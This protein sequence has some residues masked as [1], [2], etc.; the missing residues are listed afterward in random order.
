MQRKSRILSD[1]DI[2]SIAQ[3]IL[4]GDS[5]ES[6]QDPSGV[7][8]LLDEPAPEQREAGLR[9]SKVFPTEH[10]LKQYLKEH[11]GADR[12]LHTVEESPHEKSKTEETVDKSPAKVEETTK[13]QTVLDPRKQLE[14]SLGPEESKKWNTHPIHS[15]QPDIQTSTVQFPDGTKKP[16]LDLDDAE[17]KRVNQALQRGQAATRGLN[18]YTKVDMPTF[19]KNMA[20]NLSR[21]DDDTIEETKND[22][23]DPISKTSIGEFTKKAKANAKSVLDKYATSMSDVS[24]PIADRFADQ[25]LKCVEEGTIDGSL[26]GIK[27]SDLDE[28]LREDLK[29]MVSQEIESRGRSLGDHGIRHVGINAEHTFSMLNQIQS[30]GVAI[31]AKDKLMA[32]T[33][34]ANHDTGYTVGM[35]ATTFKQEVTTPSGEKVKVVNHKAN[36][37]TLARSK[38]EVA[39]YG[40]IFGKDATDNIAHIIKTHDDCNALDWEKEPVASAVRLSD[41]IAVFGKEKIQDLFLRDN[42]ALGIVCKMKL[43]AQAAPDDVEIQKNLK[44]QLHKR[45]DAGKYHDVDKEQ[46]HKM[47]D[48]MEEKRRDEA[49]NLK[50]FS[51]SEDVLSRISGRIDSVQYDAKNKMMKVGMSYTADGQIVDSGFADHIA[52]NRVGKMVG[53]IGY[54]SDGKDVKRGDITLLNQSTKKP[55]VL[56]SISGYDNPP[57]IAAESKSVKEFY[58]K[59]SRGTFAHIRKAF[60]PPPIE[61]KTA[62]EAYAYITE[63]EN[64]QKFNDEEKGAIEKLFAEKRKSDP[65]GILSALSSWP[66]LE[67]ERKYLY[68]EETTAS[69]RGNRMSTKQLV[70]ASIATKSV[71]KRLATLSDEDKQK[72]LDK[73][74]EKL[75][76]G[77]DEE[78]KEPAEETE[79]T[80]DP[81]EDV[82]ETEEPTEDVEETEED[83][84][85]EVEET[86]DPAEDVED[87]E[88]VEETSEQ[89]ISSIVKD[90]VQEVGTIKE[91]GK[92]SPAEVI[93]LIKSMMDMVGLLV[94]AK[95]P[96]RRKRRGS[97]DRIEAMT[98][99][100][101]NVSLL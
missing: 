42:D 64:W 10:Q 72:V 84:V 101:V 92:I 47:V 33:I 34:Q 43:A 58:N 44:G 11:P 2:E 57:D 86:E 93:G 70:L 63:K 49:G 59:T 28:H 77:G 8:M 99:K 75:S 5:D 13:Q 12:Q 88:S 23:S 17:K 35:A 87:G 45:I 31:T 100:I 89:D 6:Q 78:T 29:R 15:E 18:D 41:S 67:S 4:D 61:D 62:D 65:A 85:E 24:R 54:S 96:T 80:K 14:K 1:E 60:P 76:E 95:P 50:G 52:L 30:A 32:L 90:L 48:E 39:R 56:L 21:Y 55:S 83:T 73:V 38:E 46:L 82:E 9:V 74:Q 37:E 19:Q 20:N 94:E 71:F 66:L 40:K 7:I 27:Q 51:S 79:E 53:E 26:E 98:D 68:G 25:F 91:D 36:S 3:K 81:T 97:Y 22:S 69:W 16:Y